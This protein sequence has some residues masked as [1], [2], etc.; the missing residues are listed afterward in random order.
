M[1]SVMLKNNVSHVTDKNAQYLCITTTRGHTHILNANTG[2]N[3]QKRRTEL[4]RQKA[5]YHHVIDLK[6]S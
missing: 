4:V 6:L 1:N 5:T 3:R 2:Q